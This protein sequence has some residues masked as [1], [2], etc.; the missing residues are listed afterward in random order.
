QWQIFGRVIPAAETVAKIEAVTEAEIRKVAA[1]IF[2][3]RPT[4]AAIGPIGQVPRLGN[5][6]DRLAA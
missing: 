1:K 5:I 6:I 4:V 3:S 2:A